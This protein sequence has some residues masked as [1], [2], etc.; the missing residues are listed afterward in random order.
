MSL[1][2]PEVRC[3]LF[4]T[5]GGRCRRWRLDEA[6]RFGVWLRLGSNVNSRYSRAGGRQAG[7]GQ[8]RKRSQGPRAKAVCHCPGCPAKSRGPDRPDPRLLSHKVRN[9]GCFAS[10]VLNLTYTQAILAVGIV[11]FFSGP[12]P[13][14]HDPC[15]CITPSEDGFLRCACLTG[16]RT[17]IAAAV[18]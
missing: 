12:T 4:K 10:H 17:C 14:P 7:Q 16:G 13:I 15:R 9:S 5:A 3:R 18:R 1:Q 8:A 2:G 6:G 11:P